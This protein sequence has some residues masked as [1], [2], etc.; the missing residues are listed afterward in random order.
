MNDST[1][2]PHADDGAPFGTRPR[3]SM[4]PLYFLGTLYALWMCVLIWMAVQ[5]SRG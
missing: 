2:N 1:G 4:G 3:R 5:A